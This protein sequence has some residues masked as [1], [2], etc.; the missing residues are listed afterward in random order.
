MDGRSPNS[1]LSSFPKADVLDESWATLWEALADAQPDHVAVVIGDRRLTW[2][3]L[4]DRAS[5]LAG[6][7]TAAGVGHGQAIGQLM[8]NCPEYL[9]SAYASFKVR[10]S[11][12]N[13][14]Y[15]YKAPEIVHV[16]SDS[17]ATALVF[18]AAFRDV[19]DEARR[20]LPD[21]TLLV[22]VGGEDEP[23]LP[24]A[25][26][27]EEAV[28]ESS[29][30][31]RIERSGSDSLLLY[32]GG[33]TGLPKGVV[34]SHR[35]LFG[36]LAF[37]G[38]ASLGLD[39]PSTP[40]DVARVAV[41]LQASGRGPV[42]M[43]APPLMHGTAMF[44]AFSTFVLGGTVVL[45]SGRRFDAS[46]LLRLVQRERV[47]QVSIVGDAFAR[48]IVA[49]LERS[50]AVGEP[51]DVTS[52]GRIVSTGATLSSESK[53]SLMA[54]ATNALVLDMIGASEGGPFAVSMTMP[55]QDPADTARFTATPNTVL[56]DDDTWEPV[57][58]GSGR[59]GVLAA[60][61]PMPDGYFGDSERTA[62]TFR[63]IDGVRYSIPGDYAIID[64]DG[65]V[66]LLGRGSVCINT[67]GEKVY[68]EEVE[69]A[70]RSHPEVVDC[71]AVG[72]PDERFGEI[73]GLV[74]SRSTDSTIDEEEVVAHVKAAIA[75]YKAPR[76]VVFVDEVYR[77]PSGKAD[78]RWAREVASR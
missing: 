30:M 38:Y 11:T 43:T 21:L 55:G 60:A 45:L 35:G 4:D 41:D 34:W 58:F 51:Y 28:S 76:R 32:T 40:V 54:R 23:L 31:P 70:A 8:Y 15:R 5:R 64:A 59:A 39:V 73:V 72:L 42:N 47:S 71:V 33:T 61:G 67:G 65:T 69:V 75:D 62:R 50:E 74:V 27:Y 25:V 3:S 26:R 68:P 13:V 24:G 7:L 78:Y 37:T 14:N 12:V 63:E 9:E 20:S 52:L 66:H 19:V 56:F 6:V 22:Q 1:N 16:L 17:R 48:P 44:L 2:R 18:H 46:E 57:P 49:E 36:A 10:A 53:R 29:P 77:S